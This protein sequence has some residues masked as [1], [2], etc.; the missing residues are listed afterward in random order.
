MQSKRELGQY[1]TQENPFNHMVFGEW[2]E[3][4]GYDNG[5]TVLEPFA[6]ANN[7]LKLMDESG[8]HNTWKCY[9]ID[10]PSENVF[11]D[12]PVEYR[13]TIKDFPTGYDVCVTNCPYLGKSSARRRKIEYPWEED[14]LYKVCLNRMLE[15]CG[16]VAAIIPESFITAKIDKDRLWAVISL[17]CRMFSDTECP[18]CLAMFVPDKCHETRIFSND[19]YLGTIGELAKNDLSSDSDY[20]EWTFNDKDGN[21]GVKT[22]DSQK[23]ADCRFFFG[24]EINP[25]DI[26]VSSRAFTRV[27][28]L[29]EYVDRT[30]FIGVCNRILREYR[31][32]TKD[33]LMTSFKGLRAD[34]KYRRRLDF[35]TVRNIMNAAL[36]KI[37]Q[38]YMVLR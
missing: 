13:D 34:G 37:D 3:M 35:K 27:S 21:I 7:I 12:F 38:K 31:G 11:P 28:G 10:P 14:D 8:F 18:V 26:K 22:V 15:N 9:D 19:E 36:K 5:G 24:E 30:E 23:C 6:G 16:Y 2:M 32:R 4:S 25:D 29:P 1:Y 33:V 20:H 17:T